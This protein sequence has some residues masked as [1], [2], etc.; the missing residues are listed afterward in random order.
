M[1]KPSNCANASLRG[2]PRVARAF[3]AAAWPQRA[4]AKSTPRCN[5]F[6]KEGGGLNA[7]NQV[8]K[9]GAALYKL[10]CARANFILELPDLPL[11]EEESKLLDDVPK[12]D[13]TVR[14]D[15]ERFPR[16][17]ALLDKGVF[18]VEESSLH[19]FGCF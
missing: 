16:I 14:I 19:F 5:G 8:A 1:A 3:P 2:G 18:V 6:S 9:E 7:S 11:P 15:A 10:L 17:E 12:T 13:V 4:Q